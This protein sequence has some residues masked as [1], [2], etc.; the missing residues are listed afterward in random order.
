MKKIIKSMI[1]MLNYQFNKNDI[2]RGVGFNTPELN[3]ERF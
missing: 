1:Y 2:F 3:L